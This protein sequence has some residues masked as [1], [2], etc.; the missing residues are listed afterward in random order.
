[1]KVEVDLEEID[2]LTVRIAELER[3]NKNLKQTAEEHAQ[4]HRDGH[5]FRDIMSALQC[6]RQ[7][8]LEVVRTLRA[9]YEEDA[10]GTQQALAE[11]YTN[12]LDALEY[13]SVLKMM[14][15]ERGHVATTIESLRDKD[16]AQWEA[17]QEIRAA[18]ELGD[19]VP[20]QR[21]GKIIKDRIEGDRAAA[22]NYRSVL[23][24]TD[25]TPGFVVTTLNA[26]RKE[27]ESLTRQV[28]EGAQAQRLARKYRTVLSM[29]D[30]EQGCVV[31]TIDALRK[32]N[33]ELTQQVAKAKC[34]SDGSIA[35]MRMYEVVR[36]VDLVRKYYRAY[37]VIQQSYSE[38]LEQ[39]L[40]L[41]QGPG[42]TAIPVHPLPYATCTGGMVS[43]FYLHNA[44]RDARAKGF[45]AGKEKVLR[46]LESFIK[47]Q[48]KTDVMD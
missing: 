15:L 34:P 1:M 19:H 2:K 9:T 35:G 10:V 41:C 23:K 13:R 44:T 24:Q 32:A 43:T 45:R 25:L 46:N 8:V 4:L 22:L 36:V 11:G 29:T 42:A 27:N 17:L 26:L 28:K 16:K 5:T 7:D 30:I 18:L 31:P 47:A 12:E 3:E 33:E 14:E 38:W 21:Y 20:I 40:K 39:I 6:P 37:P 48:K